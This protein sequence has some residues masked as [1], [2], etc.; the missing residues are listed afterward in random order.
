MKVGDKVIFR[1]GGIYNHSS[2]SMNNVQERS[3][4]TDMVT[5]VMNHGVK[6]KNNGYVN[7]KRILRGE[8]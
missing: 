8:L 3:K 4:R 6:T 1:D 2:N 5:K 7:N